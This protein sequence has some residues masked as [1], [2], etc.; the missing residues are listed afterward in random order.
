MPLTT[1]GRH[2]L[3]PHSDD[4]KKARSRKWSRMHGDLRDKEKRLNGAKVRFVPGLRS[5]A[6][7]AGLG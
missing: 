5:H 2:S 3:A 6:L 1:T 4:G 7:L